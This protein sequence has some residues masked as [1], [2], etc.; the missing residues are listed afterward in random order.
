MTL[1]ETKL[2]QKISDLVQKNNVKLPIL[3]LR[4]IRRWDEGIE[5]PNPQEREGTGN[6][7][8]LNT[9]YDDYDLN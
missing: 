1:R 6:K 3:V 2:K 8:R 5:A 9:K 4:N 7:T